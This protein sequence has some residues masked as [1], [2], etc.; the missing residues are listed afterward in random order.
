M[1]TQE[2]TVGLDHELNKTTSIG[3]RYAHKWLNRAIEAF[4]VLEPGVGE[5]YRIA[6]PGYGWDVAPLTGPNC[7]NCPIQ[8]PAKRVYDG[9]EVRLRKRLSNSW[10]MTT[11]YTLSRLFGNYSGL[12]NSDENGRTDPNSSRGFDSL[13]ESYDAQGNAGR[14]RGCSRIGRT[15]SRCRDR[16]CSSGAPRSAAT[17]SCRAARRCR[18][19]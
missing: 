3:V 1:K 7:P 10:E 5:I 16:T 2:F 8:P 19:R 17:T 18:R 13:A 15:S 11:S 12:A 9:V 6:N 4:G 14:R